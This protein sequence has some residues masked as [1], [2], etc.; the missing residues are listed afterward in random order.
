MKAEINL[1]GKLGIVVLSTDDPYSN[2]RLDRMNGGWSMTLSRTGA[3]SCSPPIDKADMTR[4]LEACLAK[5]K[6]SP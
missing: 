4:F 5:A 2:I 6:E 3:V 1:D